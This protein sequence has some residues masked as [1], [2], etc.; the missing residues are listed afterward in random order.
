MT[1]GSPSLRRRV[2]TVMRTVLENGSSVLVP[3]ALEQLL[4]GDDR[5]LRRPAA[6]AA[7]ANSLGVRSS[8]APG[9]R[10][11]PPRGVEHDV[12]APAA[13]AARASPVRR[14]SARRRATSSAK[15]NGLGR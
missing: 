13:P 7:R 12:A 14:A 3:D 9:A 2:M 1:G 11:G 15:R 10:G 5:A 8:V 6:P 4:G